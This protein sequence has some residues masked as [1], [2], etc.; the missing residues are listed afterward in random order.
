MQATNVVTVNAQAGVNGSINP[1][2]KFSVNPG[3]SLIFAAEPLASYGVD[4]W[5][6]DGQIVQSGG[7]SFTLANIQTNTTVAVTFKLGSPNDYFANRLNLNGSSITTEGSNLDATKEP[8]EPNHAGQPGGKSVWWS[9]TAPIAGRVTI[10][11]ASSDF[12]TLLGV[13]VGV[14]VNALTPV[15][16]NDDDPDGGVTSRV[17]FDAKAGGVYEIAVDE[18]GGVAGSIKLNITMM[19]GTPRPPIYIEPSGKNIFLTWPTNA[20]SF[21]IEFSDTLSSPNWSRLTDTPGIV[22]DQHSLKIPATNA[23]RFYRLRQQ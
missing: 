9:W 8:D 10:S 5:Y 4:G 1:S 22:G 20:A 13:Y 6:L 12:D 16:S 23:T 15:A 19:D 14:A 11:T 7:N 17:T 18:L 21:V 2:G 3:A